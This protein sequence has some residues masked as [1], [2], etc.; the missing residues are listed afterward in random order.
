MRGVI[1]GARLM[2][3]GISFQL[4]RDGAEVDKVFAATVAE[5][6]NLAV[7]FVRQVMRRVRAGLGRM[8]NLLVGPADEER[9]LRLRSEGMRQSETSSLTGI[10]PR[11]VGSK[12]TS[13]CKSLLDASVARF[14]PCAILDFDVRLLDVG[15]RPLPAKDALAMRWELGGWGPSLSFLSANRR[16][17]ARHEWRLILTR[18]INVSR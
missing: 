1:F 3:I 6:G 9:I 17:T 13:N 4:E 11:L 10:P 16:E 7:G 15:Q 12:V 8:R 18:N 5:D 2:Q 14:C